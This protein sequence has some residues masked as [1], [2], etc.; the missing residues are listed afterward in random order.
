MQFVD[1]FTIVKRW[2]RLAQS[3]A[4]HT[5]FSVHVYQQRYSPDP[6]LESS[7]IFQI[8]SNVTVKWGRISN[9]RR[10]K[11]AFFPYPFKELND[12]VSLTDKSSLRGA[13]GFSHTDSRSTCIKLSNPLLNFLQ[14]S[15]QSRLFF[16][17]FL[18]LRTFLCIKIFIKVYVE[19][20]V[21]KHTMFIKNVTLFKMKIYF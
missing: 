1:Q 4:I 3:E 16:S 17:F 5:I 18:I 12:L 7:V 13:L 6:Q 20:R 10:K 9:R 14:L 2:T 19:N 21:M 15:R 11:L 8:L